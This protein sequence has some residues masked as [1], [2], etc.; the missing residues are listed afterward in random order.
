[1]EVADRLGSVRG[2]IQVRHIHQHIQKPVLWT[3]LST[4]KRRDQ[5]TPN[6]KVSLKFHKKTD[7]DLLY[8]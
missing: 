2:K 6:I 4:V 7:T 1:M 3:K 8:Q 5:S